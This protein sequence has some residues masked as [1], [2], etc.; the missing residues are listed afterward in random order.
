MS[1][2]F[3]DYCVTRTQG[4]A[5]NANQLVVWLITLELTRKSILSVAK[6]RMETISSPCTFE[7]SIKDN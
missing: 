4:F 3:S 5:K 2:I 1:S 6:N 7:V